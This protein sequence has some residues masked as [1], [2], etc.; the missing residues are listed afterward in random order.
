MHFL[1]KSFCSPKTSAPCNSKI[2]SRGNLKFSPVSFGYKATHTPIF[3]KIRE[4]V[5][6]IFLGVICHGMT[7][8]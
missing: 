3:I 4:V 6:K 1:K 8:A 7:H 5:V 2:I